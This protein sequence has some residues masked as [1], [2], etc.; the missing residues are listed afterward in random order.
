[1]RKRSILLAIAAVIFILT[2]I[3]FFAHAA[4]RDP[5]TAEAAESAL[6]EG[7]KLPESWQ[8]KL[9]QSEELITALVYPEDQSSCKFDVYVKRENDRSYTFRHGSGYNS[10]AFLGV[11]CFSMPE[12]KEEV[13]ISMNRQGICSVSID[14]GNTVTVKEIDPS[15]PFVYIFPKSYE[16]IFTTEQEERVE[17]TRRSLSFHKKP[18]PDHADG[19]FPY[20]F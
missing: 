4:G 3:L 9:A 11:V 18:H 17:P 13:F 5:Q 7:N 12:L 8:S 15:Q 16:V 10:E 20:H 1:M 6:R 14:D 2:L 19:A